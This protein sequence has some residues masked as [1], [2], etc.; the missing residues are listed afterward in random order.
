[1]NDSQPALNPAQAALLLGVSAKALRLYEQHGLL[2]PQR[3]GSG[4]RFYGAAEMERARQIVAL[5]ALGMSLADIARLLGH[6]ASGLDALL[7]A[8]QARLDGEMALLAGRLDALR[9]LRAGLASGQ[10]P[11]VSALDALTARPG[12]AVSLDLPWPWAGER[13]E[14]ARLLPVTWL[15]GPLGS[16]KTRLAMALAEALP[17]GCFAGM[18]RL[19]EDGAVA[20]AR[21]DAEPDLRMAVEPILDWLRGDGATESPALMATVV[22]LRDPSAGAVVIDLVEEGLDEASQAALGAWLRHYDN[23]ARPLLAMT[24][25]SAMLDL[26]AEDAASMVIYCPANHSPPLKVL[27]VPGAAGYEAVA[28]CLAPPEVRQRTAGMVAVMG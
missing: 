25:S 9:R 8:H 11:D 23:A 10:A 12:L 26:E 22:A 27:P 13:F 15:T 4:W 3:S 2:H 20:R 28:S 6:D 14:L 18:D 5:R 19:A 7:G 24:R 1:M 17:G 16:G 21:L